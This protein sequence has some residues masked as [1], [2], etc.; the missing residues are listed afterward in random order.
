M[1]Q[2]TIILILSLLVLFSAKAQNDTLVKP[3]PKIGLVLS[4]GGAKGLAHIGVLKVIDSLGVKID[5]IAGTSMGAIIGSLYASGYTGKQLDSIFQ[6]IDFDNIITDNLPRASKAFYERDNSEKYAVKL[7]FE[8]FKL[9][10]PSALSKGYNT[11]SLLLKLTL[12]VNDVKD[13]SEL[14]IPFFC[15]ATNIE[16]GKPVILDKGNLTQSVMASGALPSLFQPVFIDDDMLIDGGVVNNYPIDELR[17]KGM[18]II[19]GVDVQDG[20]A[21]RNALTS[22]PDVLIQINNFRT[23]NDMKTKVKKTDVYIKPDITD[24]SVVS[25][26]EGIQ[27]IKK[28]KEAAL[29]QMEMLKNLVSDK[30]NQHISRIIPTAR[31]SIT[32]KNIVVEGNKNYTRSYVLGKLKIKDNEK[33]SYKNFAKGIDNLVATNNFDS[34]E[35]QLKNAEDGEGYDLVTTLK[36]SEINTFLKLGLHYDDLYKSAALVNLTKKRLLFSNDLASLDIILGDNV[37]Y[38]FE[39]L[40][41]KGFY[42][43]VGLRSR[44]NQFHKNINAQ[45]LLDDE[46]IMS[47]GLNKI[48]A[49]LADQTNQIYL[50]TLFRR[51]FALSM[52]VEH[53]RLKVASETIL[54]PNQNDQFI[55]ENTDYLSLFGNL[56]LD[57]YDNKYFPK[58]GVY[59]NGDLHIYVHASGFVENFNQFSIAKADMGYAFSLTDKLAFNLQT[60]GGFKVGEE[61]TKTLDFALG[62]YGNNLINNFIPFVGYDFISLTGNS[63]VKASVTADFEIFKKHHITAEGNW[64]N[65]D[66]NIFESGE[67]FT[68]PDYRGYALGYA[69]DSFIGPIQAKFSYSPEQKQSVWFFN[70]GFWF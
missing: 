13:F 24:F 43:S 55:F 48:D 8:D 70:I 25:F 27:I 64:A 1:K 26:S 10:L 61:T 44:Y 40:I 66:D 12:H 59:F 15:I 18:D 65:I 5:Y 67:W 7:P 34:F 68:L 9:K 33:I 62:G 60:H 11:Y 37:R 46:Q 38:N 17:A 57:T 20:L 6:E 28:G 19:I 51:D 35:Y 22:A 63:Y 54:Q 49:K 47:T 3:E 53:K 50:Q 32:I 58:K 36:E 52:G 42:W 23:I 29:S 14:P 2:K 16:T 21:D 39:Y 30:S 31:D 4:G 41:D 69:I 56:K 45:L